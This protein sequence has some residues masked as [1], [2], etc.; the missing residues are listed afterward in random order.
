[1]RV[2]QMCYPLSMEVSMEEKDVTEKTVT[3]D[4]IN[5]EKEF[6]TRSKKIKDEFHEKECKVLRYDKY[7]K[8]LD[9]MFDNYGIRI[10]NMET[11][12]GVYITIRYKGEIGKPNFKILL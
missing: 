10:K 11:F 6:K 7:A 3:A 8:T 1:M 12:D 2:T 9:I 4:D 5:H